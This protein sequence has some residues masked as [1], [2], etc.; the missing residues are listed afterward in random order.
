V[1]KPN[2]RGSGQLEIDGSGLRAAS[3]TAL[4]NRKRL[5]N[6]VPCC[7]IVHRLGVDDNLKTAVTFPTASNMNLL[8]V[9]ILGPLGSNQ[10]TVAIDA[11][12]TKAGT[13]FGHHDSP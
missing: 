11:V 12:N 1:Q 8:F 2:R 4:Y 3:R 13:T 9:P 5:G 7:V 10:L 6:I